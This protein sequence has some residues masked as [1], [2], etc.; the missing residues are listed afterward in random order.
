MKT[1]D[2]VL[3]E[4]RIQ[5]IREAAGRVVAEKGIEATT[6]E[7]IAEAAGIAK[8][9]IYLYFK[10]REDLLQKTAEHALGGL[11]SE[12][13]STFG[14]HGS[15]R[16]QFESFVRHT[17]QFFDTQRDFFRLYRAVVEHAGRCEAHLQHPL[18]QRYLRELAQWLAAAAARGE[19]VTGEQPQRL[20]LVVAEAIHAVLM[21]RSREEE[22][23]PVEGEAAWLSALLLDGIAAR[24][25]AP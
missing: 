12:I 3:Q 22:R 13:E 24:G 20:A 21:Q 23:P 11:V 25:E 18:Y 5:A 2:E 15:F 6:M 8:G 19:I 9:T 14:E 4:F 17:L 16:Q 7:A 10:N 1:K